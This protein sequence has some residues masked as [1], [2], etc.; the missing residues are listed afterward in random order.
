MSTND[1]LDT[2]AQEK[3][4]SDRKEAAERTEHQRTEDFKWL[5][6]DPR[7][8]RIVWWLLEQAGVY[9]SSFTGNS[10]TFFREGER[11]IGLKIVFMIHSHC[12]EL[13]AKMTKENANDK[14]TSTKRPNEQ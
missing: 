14:P 6:A 2:K 11:N 13:Y 8:R 1:P 7:G 4:E 5:M 10:E 3:A 12:P 9:R